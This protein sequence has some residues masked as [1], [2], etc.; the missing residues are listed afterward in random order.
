MKVARTRE[1]LRV[2]LDALS[3][4]LGLVP[5]MGYLHEGHLSL[6]RRS[7]VD[8]D[9]TAISI[10]VN[11]LQFGPN[12]DF[13]SYPRDEER[14]L[15]LAQSVGVDLAFIPS[16]E[17]MYPEGADTIVSVGRLGEI[18]EGAARPGHFNGVA[19]VVAKLFNLVRPTRA[20]F[21]QKDAQQVAVI[22]QVVRDLAIPVEIVVGPIVREPTGLALSSR[23]SYL[24]DDERERALVLY[25][26]LL[27]GAAEL[28]RSDDPM[29]AEKQMHEVIEAERGV[30]LDYARVVDPDTFEAATRRKRLLVLAARVGSTRLIDNLLIEPSENEEER[31]VA[32]GG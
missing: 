23:N 11:P 17:V 6:M 20:Y 18:V 26:A 10:F 22:R 13:A 9:H 28:E 8:N 7:V 27:A 12:E 3:G 16:V 30:V 1:E 24:T 15:D 29:L 19:T 4:S 31:P 32:A 14:D 21:G 25:Q 2:A 5:T